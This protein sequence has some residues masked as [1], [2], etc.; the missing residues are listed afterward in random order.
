VGINAP[1]IY[2][3]TELKSGPNFVNPEAPNPP[4]PIAPKFNDGFQLNPL[5][6]AVAIAAV[7][8][9]PAAN[10]KVRL[11]LEGPVGFVEGRLFFL[12]SLSSSP[13]VSWDSSRRRSGRGFFVVV[14]LGFF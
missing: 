5:V 2:P 12:S 11:D 13:E 14:V 9:L 10:G 7:P 4:K 8:A 6:A 3:A 1:F